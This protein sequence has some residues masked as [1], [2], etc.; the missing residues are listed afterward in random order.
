M[1]SQDV[2][3]FNDTIAANIAYGAGRVARVDAATRCRRPSARPPTRR[4]SLQV[5]ED[6]P[7][8]F[9]TM[10]GEN[11]VRLSGGQRQRLA[12]ARAVLKDAPILILDEAT[13]ALDSE[14]ER[15]VQAALSDLM[16]RPHDGRHRA[17]AVDDRERRPHRGVRPAAASSR[18]ARTPRCSRPTAST[19]SCIAS[20][21]R[22]T[23]ATRRARRST[24]R[25]RHADGGMTSRKAGVV[26]VAD[27]HR[28]HRVVVRLGR[29]GTPHPRRGARHDRARPSRHA[30]RAGR[31]RASS[32]R[33]RA[34]GVPVTALPIEKK[35]LGGVG[36]LRDWLRQ[37]SGATS[38]TRTARPT[39]GSSRSRGRRCARPPAIVRT[40]HIS[41]P[42]PDNLA[43]RWL[44]RDASR[45][46]VTTGESLRAQ[47]IERLRLDASRVL[48]IPTG[49]DTQGVPSADRARTEGRSKRGRRRRRHV[50]R[51]HRRHAAQLEGTSLPD[52]RL[53]ARH[54]PARRRATDASS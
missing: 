28:A 3:L 33:R 37:P 38:S 10:I 24:R 11:G 13:S 21:T 31:P 30:D 12:I 47:L 7:D 14:S 6:L 16:Q 8:G 15:H 44:Y 45:F 41:A 1:V 22:S 49:I 29:P 51:R 5:I 48:S 18:S 26:D 25:V 19:R 40:R 35:R 32:P 46:V 4:T 53:R 2:V 20:S 27:A 42:V 34:I 23:A 54:S 17:S 9:D 50:R 36:A 39:A 52:R 43:T